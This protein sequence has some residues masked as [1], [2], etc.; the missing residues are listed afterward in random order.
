MPTDLYYGSV[1]QF[2]FV[3]LI[4]QVKV[5]EN[6]QQLSPVAAA[7]DGGSECDTCGVERGRGRGDNCQHRVL[8][9]G[10]RGLTI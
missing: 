7:G 9:R 1:G 6:R 2:N 8:I 10:G 5:I 4:Q 3:R